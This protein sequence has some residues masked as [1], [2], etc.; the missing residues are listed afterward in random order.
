MVG[1]R[2]KEGG[3]DVEDESMV[4]DIAKKKN[5]RKQEM[6]KDLDEG[7]QYHVKVESRMYLHSWWVTE[8]TSNLL[9]E[10][11]IVYKKKNLFI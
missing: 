9:K 10:K 8:C 5:W 6:V 4:R 2:G 11:N 3:L 1:Y 7:S